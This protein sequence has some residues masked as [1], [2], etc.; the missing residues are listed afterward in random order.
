[1][2]NGLLGATLGGAAAGLVVSLSGNAI[3]AAYVGAA[4]ESVVN[5]A[6]T[7]VPMMVDTAKELNAEN[8]QDSILTVTVE[9]LKNGTVAALIG[10][11]V[12]SILPNANVNVKPQNLKDAFFSS[13]ALEIHLK[14]AVEGYFTTLKDLILR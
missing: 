14:T 6:I 2:S 8:I 3:L 7:Y 10:G 5:E 9:T 13:E 12:D 1:M 4:T 11:F